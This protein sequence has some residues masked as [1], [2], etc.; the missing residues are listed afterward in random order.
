MLVPK[1]QRFSCS[2]WELFAGSNGAIGRPLRS[3]ALRSGVWSRQATSCLIHLQAGGP[4]SGFII[5]SRRHA[6]GYVVVV[7]AASEFA[8]GFVIDCAGL[9]ITTSAARLSGERA[10]GGAELHRAVG[11]RIARA[12]PGKCRRDLYGRGRTVRYTHRVRRQLRHR[13]NGRNVVVTHGGVAGVV[14]I[15]GVGGLYGVRASRIL[16]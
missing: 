4:A 12:G 11:G 15:T 5:S 6:R 9:D 10:R 2:V 16:G 13:R 14:G 3:V 8:G 1:G 7:R